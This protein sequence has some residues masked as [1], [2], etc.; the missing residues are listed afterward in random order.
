M[1]VV[2][3]EA[4]VG[5]GTSSDESH[6]LVI[7]R[8]KAYPWKMQPKATSYLDDFWMLLAGAKERGGGGHGPGKPSQVTSTGAGAAAA[9]ENGCSSTATGSAAGPAQQLP[10]GQQP[11]SAL[12]GGL[13][14]IR[15]D[16]ALKKC[17]TMYSESSVPKSVTRRQEMDAA[18]VLPVKCVMCARRFVDAATLAAHMR[19]CKRK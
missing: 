5:K 7:H 19:S 14:A 1:E 17:G 6:D 8:G 9:D 11:L 12:E 3:L 16:L 10:T 18:D 13:H 2:F 4:G 15:M